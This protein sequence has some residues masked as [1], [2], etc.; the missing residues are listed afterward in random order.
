MNIF[1][2]PSHVP[3]LPN[4]KYFFVFLIENFRELCMC[5]HSSSNFVVGASSR[6]VIVWDVKT[7]EMKWQLEASISLL[8]A[9]P[10]SKY[11]SVIVSTE[12]RNQSCKTSC[13]L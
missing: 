8:T 12:G 13:I 11:F 3:L 9:D 4:H 7:F 2:Y 1:T 10:F 6:R 5:N